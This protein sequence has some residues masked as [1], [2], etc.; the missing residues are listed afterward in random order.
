[1]DER[2][3]QAEAALRAVGLTPER[4]GAVDWELAVREEMDRVVSR[5]STPLVGLRSPLSK[6]L[7]LPSVAVPPPPPRE[8]TCKVCEDGQLVLTRRTEDGVRRAAVPCPECVPLAERLRRSGVDVRFLHAA[9]ESLIVRE[10]NEVAV[11]MVRHWDLRRSVVLFSRETPGDS[12]FGTGK[13]HLAVAMITKRVR[14]GY[15]ARFIVMQDYLEDMKARFDLDGES[16]Q[17]YADRIAAEPMLLIDDLGREQATPWSGP[18]IYRLL[19]AR[20]AAGLPT[21][22]TTNYHKP[23]ELAEV[24]GGATA[25]RLRDFLWVPVGGP[26]MRGVAPGN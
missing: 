1:M 16:A 6:T 8:F 14:L 21:V 9:E 18:Q 23:A 20:W 22:V 25:S 15:P 10:G 19:N 24:V 17:A 4:C 26:D 7:A 5:A 11:G 3:Q 13:T 12:D 2:Q